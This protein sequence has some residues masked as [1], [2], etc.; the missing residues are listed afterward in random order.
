M[1]FMI[2]LT[3]IKYVI[4]LPFVFIFIKPLRYVTGFS[5]PIPLEHSTIPPRPQRA[6][7]PASRSVHPMP[8]SDGSSEMAPKRYKGYVEP[9]RPDEMEDYERLHK[10]LGISPEPGSST[11][12]SSYC[13]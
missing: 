13:P 12:S 1:F 5:I 6:G 2:I 7:A 10:K 11:G 9:I 3:P 4:V 8:P